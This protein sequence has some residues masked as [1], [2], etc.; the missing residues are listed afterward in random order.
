MCAG[1]SAYLVPVR[2]HH[3]YFVPGYESGVTDAYQPEVGVGDGAPEC[4][5]RDD[6]LR[7]SYARLVE[8]GKAI[9]EHRL[10]PIVKVYGHK[11]AI[12]D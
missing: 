2:R 5:P 11:S 12:G 7:G 9:V 3:V 1:V 10:I 8:D 4:V 6:V